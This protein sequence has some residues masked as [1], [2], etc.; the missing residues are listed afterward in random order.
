LQ[1]GV[2]GRVVI[3]AAA[4]APTVVVVAMEIESKVGDLQ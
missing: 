2:I 3:A 1:Y 4:A